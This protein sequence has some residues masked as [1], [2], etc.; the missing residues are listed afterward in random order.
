M[1]NTK[2]FSL[3]ELIFAIVII[4]IISTVAVPKLLNTKDNAEA[5]IV[6]KDISTIVSSVR[7]YYM[8]NDKLDN[9]EDA[10]T[11]NPNTWEIDGTTATYEDDDTSCVSV[12]IENKKLNVIL[13]DENSGSVCEKII[14][15]GLSSSIYDL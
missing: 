7:A 3:L 6:Q 11:L 9:F 8:V 12:N 4:G 5:A 14:A 15:S 2:A 13:N 10:L 1:V